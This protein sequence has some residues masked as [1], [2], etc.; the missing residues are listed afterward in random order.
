MYGIK[1]PLK[2]YHECRKCCFEYDMYKTTSKPF[3]E[4]YILSSNFNRACYQTS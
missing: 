4:E 3:K 2:G 1:V